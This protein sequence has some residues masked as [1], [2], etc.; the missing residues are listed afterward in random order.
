MHRSR[1]TTELLAA[2][3]LMLTTACCSPEASGDASAE[4]EANDFDV[5]GAGTE[6]AVTESA[7]DLGLATLGAPAPNFT[8]TDTRGTAHSLSD[9]RGQTVVLEWVNHGCPFVKKHYA[10]EN[11]QGLQARYTEQGVVWLSI[12]SSAPG[13]Q[14]HMTNDDWNAAIAELG[15]APTALLVDADGT[16][17]KQYQAMTTPHMYVID[18]EGTL[19]YNGAID[20]D[21]SANPNAAATANNFVAQTVDALLA[22]ETVEPFGNRSYG[23]GVKYAN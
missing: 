15:A 11:M 10:S 23:C 19:I 1:F 9:F 2:G 3:L 22:G 14:G 4:A 12:C 8:L 7:A 5:S 16:V 21:R 17:G 18:A 6:I 20:D 13:K